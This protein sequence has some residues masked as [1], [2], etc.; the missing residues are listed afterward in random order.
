MRLQASAG[1]QAVGRMLQRRVIKVHHRSKADSE[2]A[3][4]RQQVEGMATRAALGP[5]AGAVDNNHLATPGSLA[6]IQAPEMVIL[7]GHGNIATMQGYNGGEIAALLKDGWQLPQ[8]Y[9]GII[10]I[11]ACRAGDT[12]GWTTLFAASLVADVSNALR[13]YAA[14]VQG[15]KGN[16]ATS[17][18]EDPH[19]GM[20]RS[21]GSPSR[22]DEYNRLLQAW[23]NLKRLRD[24]ELAGGA[25]GW[26]ATQASIARLQLVTLREQL[27]AQEKEGVIAA[28]L[29]WV[30]S[31]LSQVTPLAER[32]ASAEKDERDNQAI[33][34]VHAQKVNAKWAQQLNDAL[35]ALDRAGVPFGDPSVTVSLGP[36][37][38]V[39][40]AEAWTTFLLQEAAKLDQQPAVVTV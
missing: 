16:V 13:G 26:A 12:G 17:G 9:N 3:T 31:A 20:P 39:T 21:V 1:N 35:A 8:Q 34:D 14:T 23:V 6:G 40:L 2:A 22:I 15:M 5:N 32:I 19:P 24:R 11:D 25:G 18:E 36:A 38:R 10:R 7:A 30:T 37:D 4:D 27:K 33:A 29:T 28:S